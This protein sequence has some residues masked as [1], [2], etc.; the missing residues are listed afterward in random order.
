MS[1][2]VKGTILKLLVTLMALTML[3]GCGSP[4]N[5]NNT[6]STATGTATSVAASTTAAEKAAPV[7]LVLWTGSWAKPTNDPSNERVKKAI[8]EKL[9]IDIQVV[10]SPPENA[11]EKLNLMLASGDQLDIA[12]LPQ[13]DLVKYYK[14]GAVTGLNELIDK[15]GL[16]IKKIV[17]AD[18]W[19]LCKTDDGTILQIPNVTDGDQNY[20]IVRNDLLKKYGMGTPKTLDEYEA[21]LEKAKEDGLV[22]LYYETAAGSIDGI[23]KAFGGMFL[24]DGYPGSV[25]QGSAIGYDEKGKLVDI[26]RVPGY[27]DIISKLADW[28]KK[29]YISKDLYAW[30]NDKKDTMFGQGKVASLIGWASDGISTYATFF[31]DNPTANYV[32]CDPMVGPKGTNAGTQ[33]LG[34]SNGCFIPA[35]SKVKDT[36]MKYMN[37]LLA[38]VDNYML[39]TYGVKGVDWD[40]VNKDTFSYKTIKNDLPPYMFSF[41]YFD[42]YGGKIR[43]ANAPPNMIL[44]YNM[45]NQYPVHAKLVPNNRFKATNYGLFADAN[46][47]NNLTDLNDF[48]TQQLAK[49]I[50]GET[51]MSQWDSFI[52]DYLKRGG[53]AYD[54]IRDKVWNDNKSKLGG[55]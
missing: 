25:D 33:E 38:D 1:R 23:Y 12:S 16:D 7:K 28:Y 29:G 42:F 30:T 8:D 2:I 15:Y 21:Y 22:P 40:W 26:I 34:F 4:K 43:D 37:W 19:P 3:A 20:F 53:Q 51:P 39:A 10:V 36:A 6:N 27:K 44:Y 17:P 52:Q 55:N 9:N 47:K 5:N 54:D 49:F 13:T 41:Y 45:Y 50:T 32:Y 11:T 31:K 24:Q 14:D 35:N 46:S 18:I 48:K